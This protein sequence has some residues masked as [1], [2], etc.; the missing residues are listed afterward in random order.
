MYWQVGGSRRVEETK[1]KFYSE[2]HKNERLY[3][4]IQVH[5]SA[6]SCLLYQMCVIYPMSAVLLKRDFK[7]PDKCIKTCI[8]KHDT[9]TDTKPTHKQANK[10]NLMHTQTDLHAHKCTHVSER[11]E[12][13][14]KE[15]SVSTP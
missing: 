9:H 1:G 14:R 11:K 12:K 5:V 4:T 10:H 2:E 8:H 13:E 15:S 7:I 6:L 3:R